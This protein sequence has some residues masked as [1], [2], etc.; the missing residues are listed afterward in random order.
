MKGITKKKKIITLI[1]FLSFTSAS[2]PL[3][4]YKHKQNELQI[5]S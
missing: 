3:T 2:C 1:D 5:C 4:L